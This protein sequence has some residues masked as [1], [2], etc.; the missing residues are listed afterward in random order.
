VNDAVVYFSD[1]DSVPAALLTELDGSAQVLRNEA[2]AFPGRTSACEEMAEWLTGQ[3][4]LLEQ[5]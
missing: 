1:A 4:R 2:N 3:K 5:T